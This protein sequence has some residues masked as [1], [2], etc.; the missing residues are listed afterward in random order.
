MTREIVARWREEDGEGVQHLV[1]R[2]DAAGVMA[3]AAALSGSGA[4]GFA[5]VFRIACDE[6]WRV[7]RAEIGVIGGGRVV[8]EADGT[9]HWRVDGSPLP[10][11]DGALD[12]DLPI[13][14]FTNTLPIRRLGLREGESA[15]IIS[16]YV[17]M[18]SLSVTADP[19]RYTC[20]GYRRLY[21]Y[22]SR[23]SDFRRDITTDDEG[24]VID[25]PGLFRRIT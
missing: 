20:L 2:M 12:I 11:L 14:P 22:E 6:S 3:E 1:L 15:D 4:A 8:L 10:T 19:Q 18:P 5:A 17:E 23:D 25:Y 13:T 7:R 16:A 9:G 24:L 21:R